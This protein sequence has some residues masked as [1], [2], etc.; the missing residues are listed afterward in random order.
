MHAARA[1]AAAATQAARATQQ[2]ARATAAATSQAPR[3]TQQAARAMAKAAR[4]AARATWHG[5]FHQEHPVKLVHRMLSQLV[6][7][8]H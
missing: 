2:A 7:P 6:K 1:T 4:Q 5:T 8:V 3:A